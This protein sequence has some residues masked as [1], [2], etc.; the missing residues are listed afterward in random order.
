MPPKRNPAALTA[1]RPVRVV[2]T[3]GGKLIA[4]AAR[5]AGRQPAPTPPPR[6]S[7]SPPPLDVDA[8]GT[9]M[10]TL[11]QIQG[12][13][14][15]FHNLEAIIDE[16][17]CEFRASLQDTFTQFMDRFDALEHRGSDSAL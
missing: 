14:D 2:K 3:K 13:G 17:Q 6:E 9:V 16:N 7:V 1:P 11:P 15:R 5:G 4:A 12:L 10:S 8:L